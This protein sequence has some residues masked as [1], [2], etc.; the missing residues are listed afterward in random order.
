[1]RHF[2]APGGLLAALTDI[3]A[4]CV[5]DVLEIWAHISKKNVVSASPISDMH[6]VC[7]Y[8]YTAL[9]KIPRS[10]SCLEN[11]ETSGRY[12]MRENWRLSRLFL[13]PPDSFL[14]LFRA[15]A[16]WR[17]SV[18]VVGREIAKK[19]PRFHTKNTLWCMSKHRCLFLFFFFFFVLFAFSLYFLRFNL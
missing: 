14:P 8:R 19:N 12:W 17:Q 10:A 2:P 16:S 5:W 15:V 7:C 9:L 18:S 3:F 13:C 4:I 6:H 1:M 11:V